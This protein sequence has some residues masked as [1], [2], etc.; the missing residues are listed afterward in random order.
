MKVVLIVIDC[1]HACIWSWVCWVVVV[2]ACR[3]VVKYVE[4]CENVE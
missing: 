1:I 3:T 4:L 2:C